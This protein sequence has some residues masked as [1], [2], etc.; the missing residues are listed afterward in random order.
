MLEEKWIDILQNILEKTEKN[1]DVFVSKYPHVGI[2]N[3]Y[4]PEENVLWTSSFLI[5]MAY[6]AYDVTGDRNYIRHRL[7]YLES[8]ENRLQKRIGISHDLGFLYTLTAIAD[9]R[10]TGDERSGRLA[11]KAADM[12]AERYNEKGR[13]IQ[14]WHEIGAGYPDANI[15]IDTMMNLPLLYGSGN[16]AYFDM[17]RNHAMTAAHTLVRKDYSTFHGYLVRP[18]TGEMVK[19]VT[20]QGY[21]DCWNWQNMRSQKKRKNIGKSYIRLWYH[22]RSIILWE[23]RITAYWQRECIIG[24]KEQ[25]NA[26]S[27]AII[28]IWKLQFVC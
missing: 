6:L 18:E 14:A 20:Y 19:G 22:Y 24:I 7:K 2:K 17:A 26:L 8:F 21:A 9:Y 27:G 25:T 15:I 1:L 5:G 16:P 13:Y 4:C 28:F 12:L 11:G 10:L 23:N 3:Q